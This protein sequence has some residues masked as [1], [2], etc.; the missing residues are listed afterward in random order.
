MQ[1]VSESESA[2][3]CNNADSFLED[4]REVYENVFNS[5]TCETPKMTDSVIKDFLKYAPLRLDEQ[6]QDGDDI[7][8]QPLV[9]EEDY[10]DDEICFNLRK[11]KQLMQFQ[12]TAEF[13]DSEYSAET[14][15]NTTF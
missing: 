11:D 8:E 1:G 3:L 10:D 7:D 13:I 5:F 4:N 12:H 14:S 2:Q 15:P 6:L 9:V